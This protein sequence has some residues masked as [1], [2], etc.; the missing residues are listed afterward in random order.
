[1]VPFVRGDSPVTAGPSV[2]GI[3]SSI[4]LPR[5]IGRRVPSLRGV[6]K[7]P[8]AGAFPNPATGLRP[9]RLGRTEDNGLRAGRAA[10]CCMFERR[11]RRP[12]AT[13]AVTAVC[14][15]GLVLGSWSGELR[16]GPADSSP[17]LYGASELVSA[18]SAITAPSGPNHGNPVTCSA[19]SSLSESCGPRTTTTPRSTS[20]PSWSNITSRV[21]PLPSP[22][23][24]TMVRDASDG[25]VL[26][27]GAFYLATNNSEE[28][29]KDTWSYLNGVWTN[30]TTQVTGGPPPEPVD[31]VMAYDPWTSEVV[32]F[33]GTSTASENLS[34]TWT[35]HALVWTN[36]TATAGTPPSPRWL[37]V[38][39][40]DL[41]SHQMI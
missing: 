39:V 25:Y 18:I 3:R 21:V 5:A 24:S 8:D 35:Y 37:P 19:T 16:T 11:D 36:I 7:E 20:S 10:L 17:N 27:Y 1:M 14:M 26:L 22:R 41:A 28:Q 12:F 30:L 23:F 32:L 31:P 38:F 6:P 40:A 33:G 29:V 15:L 9:N 4:R 2:A 13:L 34:L